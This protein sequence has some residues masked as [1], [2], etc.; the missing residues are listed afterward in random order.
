VQTEFGEL[1]TDTLMGVSAMDSKLKM[2]AM[3][4]AK[5][6]IPD[7]LLK[8]MITDFKSSTFDANPIVYAK[9]MPFYRKVVSELFPVN[10]EMQ[11][12]VESIS[13]GTLALPKKFNPFTVLFDQVPMIWDRD[14][15]SFVS[16]REKLGLV[17]IDGEMINTNITAYIEV[18][19]PTNDD[20]RLY[21]YIKSPSQQYYFFG[22][23]QGILNLVSNNTRFM[24]ELLKMKDKDKIF[25]MPDGE[26]Y[27][28]QPVEPSTASAF[29]NRV[30]AAKKN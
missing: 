12:V 19:M 6:I 14:Y 23:K 20:D 29:V 11:K 27:E 1:V 26:Q 4:G 7:N 25:K 17:S 3:I 18:K 30:E 24:D 22:Y 9:D 8:I 21:I 16:T 28:I 5:L 10:E 15:Q 2:E 13:T